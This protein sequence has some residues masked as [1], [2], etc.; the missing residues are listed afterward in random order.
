VK[1]AAIQILKNEHLA[2]AAVL[3]ALHWLARGMRKG[4]APNFPVLRAILDYIV[5]YPDRWHH[6][7]EDTHLFTAI[8]SRTH[9]ADALIAR[10]E[11]EHRLGHPMVEDLK[12]E[13]IALQNG[14]DGALEAFCSCA[15]RYAELEWRHLRTEEDQLLPIAERVLLPEDWRAIHEAF[16]ENDNPLFGIK[17]K[18]EADALYQ[19]ILALAPSP[20]GPPA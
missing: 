5:S 11:R 18:D 16:L 6:P 12:R 15:I 7:K 19:R 14:E 1:T 20:I 8:R 17:P 2:I 4:E 10:L 3:Y 9:E 13:L